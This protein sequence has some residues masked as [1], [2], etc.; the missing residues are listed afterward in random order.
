[1]E[2]L[3]SLW[4]L[5]KASTSRVS[6]TAAM[7]AA[8]QKTPGK[9]EHIL[10][11]LAARLCVVHKALDLPSPDEQQILWRRLEKLLRQLERVCTVSILAN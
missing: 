7:L 9:S 5:A 2:N 3:D 4:E 1:M 8:S 11:E 6:Y 10:G